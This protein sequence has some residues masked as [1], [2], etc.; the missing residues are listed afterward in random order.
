RLLA[1]TMRLK[2]L[3]FLTSSIANRAFA[4]E[5]APPQERHRHQ[6]AGAKQSESGRL[7]DLL[8]NNII[9]ICEMCNPPKGLILTERD[10][11]ASAGIIPCARHFM[12]VF[13]RLTLDCV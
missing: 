2:H 3:R 4:R 7:R 8:K 9:Q 13:V 5:I 6:N 12:V 10:C 11:K 1:G